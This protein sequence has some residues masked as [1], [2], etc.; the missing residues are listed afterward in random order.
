MVLMGLGRLGP[1]RFTRMSLVT[2]L[3]GASPAR[4]PLMVA[5]ADDLG[6]D[7]WWQYASFG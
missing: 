1:Q 7:R 3:C 6:G 2:S 4:W 5:L